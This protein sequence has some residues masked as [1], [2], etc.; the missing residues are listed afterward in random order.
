MMEEDA[1]L[2]ELDEQYSNYLAEE[3]EKSLGFA[4]CIGD[5]EESP[6]KEENRS[7]ETKDPLVE[8]DLGNGNVRHPLF[9]S[10]LLDE[11]IRSK[12]VGVL[13]RHSDCFAWDYHKLPGLSREII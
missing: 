11:R 2:R 4:D 1:L 9:V 7:I 13:R 8:I 10:R 3:I 12:L 6:I 5:F